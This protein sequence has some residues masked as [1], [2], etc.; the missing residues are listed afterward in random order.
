MRI[1]SAKVSPLT[2]DDP[3]R[4]VIPTIRPPNRFIALSNDNRVRVEGSKN[5]E[6]KI[7]PVNGDADFVPSAIGTIDSA[8]FKINSISVLV[9]SRIETIFRPKNV[10]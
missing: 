2:S 6:D 10:S 3:S 7:L 9:K 8:Q 1:V 5:N 4:S